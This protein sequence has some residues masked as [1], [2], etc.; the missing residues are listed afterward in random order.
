MGCGQEN[1]HGRFGLAGWELSLP[2]SHGSD[3]RERNTLHRGLTTAWIVRFSHPV[4]SCVAV[5]W[6]NCLR[7]TS[8][9]RSYSIAS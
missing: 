1:A 7:N 4:T 2:L 6:G 5:T 3:P 9:T 8:M